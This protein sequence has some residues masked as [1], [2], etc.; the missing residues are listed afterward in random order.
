MGSISYRTPL[1][2]RDSI[3]DYM[4]T[5]LPAGHTIVASSIA[6]TGRH[7]KEDYTTV[8]YFAVN[9]GEHTTAH[10]ILGLKHEG[11]AVIKALHEDMLT[12]HRGMTAKVLNALT[13]TTNETA[14]EWRR[15]AQGFIDYRASINTIVN[16]AR[17]TGELVKLNTALD[18][19][20]AGAI[21]EVYIN[22]DG[23]WHSPDRHYRLRKPA[24]AWQL[25][26]A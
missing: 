21:T 14:L 1:N 18:Y 7:P 17:K 4:A 6:P 23:S 12:E 5:N 22:P 19:R 13:P 11:H 26:A 20:A 8:G 15:R 25:I 10:V 2:A 16:N 3:R 24:H 9:D